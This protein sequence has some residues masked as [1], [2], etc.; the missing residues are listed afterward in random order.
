MDMINVVMKAKYVI[1]EYAGQ[2]VPI[3]FSSML[4]HH[5]M[6]GMGRCKGA[7]F[8]E[9]DAT[10]KWIISGRS[11]TL[12]LMSRPQDAQAL[13]SHIFNRALTLAAMQLGTG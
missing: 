9:L 6:V 7:G 10:G 12:C 11:D 4:P 5:F 1:I 13:T 3:V 2:E 8:C